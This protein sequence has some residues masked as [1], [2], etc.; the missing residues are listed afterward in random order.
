VLVQAG[1]VPLIPASH[2]S[3]F[4]QVQTAVREFSN[5]LAALPCSLVRI[6]RAFIG[7]GTTKSR[8]KERDF[9]TMKKA[10]DHARVFPCIVYFALTMLAA[11][12]VETMGGSGRGRSSGS[13]LQA[14]PEALRSAARAGR[15]DEV[16]R[17][18]GAGLDPNA[19]DQYGV[20]ALIEAAQRGNADVIRI[21]TRARADVNYQPPKGDAALI[22][23]AAAGHFDAVQ[24]LVE[25]KADLNIVGKSNLGGTAI[26]RAAALEHWSTV[27]FLAEAGADPNASGSAWPALA[28]AAEK[29]REKLVHL[30]LEKGADPNYRFPGGASVIWQPV[31]QGHTEIVRLLLESGARV[32][33]KDRKVLLK[34]LGGK[35]INPEIKQLLLKPPKVKRLARTSGKKQATATSPNMNE[36][37]KAESAKQA[38]ASNAAFPPLGQAVG[39]LVFNKQE[40]PLAYSYA[41]VEEGSGKKSAKKNVVILLTNIPLADEV[42]REWTE[43]SR[44]ADEGKLQAV[45]LTISPEK[46]VISGQFWHK[47][48]SF[49]ATGMHE[50]EPVTFDK[51][52]AAGVLSIPSE[53]EFFG[54]TYRYR[55]NFAARIA[56]P[57]QAKTTSTP[58][59]SSA[60]EQSAQGKVYRAYLKAMRDNNLT[61]VKGYVTKDRR[62]ELEAKMQDPEF[63]AMF[64]MIRAFGPSE[65]TLLRIQETGDKAELSVSGKQ[66][67]GSAGTGA[68]SFV[69]E[70]SEWRILEDSWKWK[71]K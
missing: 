67:D 5:F 54:T 24:A 6:C 40:T 45:E 52:V 68:I 44:L 17:L 10:G 37:T 59:E 8:F 63:K 66:D 51:K 21:L 31:W 70:E 23:A 61:A 11:G 55:A 48:K 69:K 30:L 62:L 71:S 50:F 18:L 13:D 56:Q 14:T 25:A 38:T 26:S 9:R 64:D 27:G 57:V 32:P 60:A 15:A 1:N 7:F 2:L 42:V 58:A 53:H 39:T 47:D 16:Q 20:T 34:G 4:L 3:L 33:A 41:F 46:H 28:P 29:N 19:Q 43:K 12:C 65:V 22:E 49:S 36:A 35:P